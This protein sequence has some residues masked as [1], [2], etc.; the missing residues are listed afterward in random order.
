MD[1]RKPILNKD[2][3]NLFHVKVLSFWSIEFPVLESAFNCLIMGFFA[4]K[5]ILST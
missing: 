3:K 4:E 5:K 1:R 2:E